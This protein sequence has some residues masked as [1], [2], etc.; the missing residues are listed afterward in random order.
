MSTL[1]VGI[2]KSTTAAP[3]VVQNSSE[4][5]VG[6]FCRAYANFNG[7]GTPAIRSSFNVVGIT[8]NGV[9]DFTLT[10]VNPLPSAN[11]AS[12]VVAHGISDTFAPAGT[13]TYSTASVR[14]MVGSGLSG[15]MTQSWGVYKS[16]PAYINVAIF[17]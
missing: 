4:I 12:I 15:Y 5:E 13:H 2:L 14:V 7:S 17:L 16:D 8:D 3:P 11:Y 1:G 10:F 6:R 9:G